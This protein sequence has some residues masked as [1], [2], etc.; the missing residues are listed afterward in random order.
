MVTAWQRSPTSGM[1]T[2]IPRRVRGRGYTVPYNALPC[3]CDRYW[4]HSSEPGSGSG[5][6]YPHHNKDCRQTKFQNV[7][8][9]VY[10]LHLVCGGLYAYDT[11]DIDDW[12]AWR[13]RVKDADVRFDGDLAL[14]LNTGGERVVLTPF[15]S[16]CTTEPLDYGDITPWSKPPPRTGNTSRWSGSWEA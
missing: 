8:K 12:N 2:Q 14:W 3:A 11:V 10:R 9:E 6:N 4:N 13:K 16:N 7:F 1:G 15:P 5:Y